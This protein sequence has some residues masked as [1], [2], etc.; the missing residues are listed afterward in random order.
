MERPTGAPTSRRTVL[1]GAAWSVPV[2]AASTAVAPTASASTGGG[3][4]QL[5]LSAGCLLGVGGIEVA[6]GFRMENV[7]DGP[8]PTTALS[9]SMVYRSAG[10]ISSVALA[11]T[12][13]TVELL[14]NGLLSYP[15]AGVTQT[16]GYNSPASAPVV[17]P[18]APGV[19][20]RSASPSRAR[21]P[22]HRSQQAGRPGSATSRE[23][24]WR[25]ATSTAPSPTA[26]PPPRWT[27]RS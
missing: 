7:G 19:P 21:S 11:R 8:T 5:V 27:I 20:V 10:G 9:Q 6:S 13:M 24:A 12:F 2:V 16:S 1:K 15:G 14:G 17:R 25:W 4:G 23:S 22:W 26:T 18:P 3:T